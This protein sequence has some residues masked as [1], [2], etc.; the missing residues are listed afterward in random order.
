MTFK[1]RISRLVKE[2]EIRIV[3]Y[4]KALIPLNGKSIIS[5]I[6]NCYPRSLEF[7]I[8]V[9]YR[10]DLIKKYLKITHPDKKFKFVKVDNY[11][12]I[13]S[14]PGYSLLKCKKYLQVPF[15]SHACD[16]VIENKISELT[17]NWVG[18]DKIINKHLSKFVSVKIK[19]NGKANFK[20]INNKGNIF[21]GVAG[22]YDY[23]NFWKSLEKNNF[24]SKKLSKK[25]SYEKQMI[26]GFEEL[27]KIKLKKL[28]WH[29][30]GDDFTYEQIYFKNV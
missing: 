16:A 17:H 30:A 20:R 22:I 3:K 28:K 10:S 14:G 24:F 7:V 2:Q 25:N 29:D 26:D 11:E 23:K 4:H 6:I 21:V 5:N 12:G 8:A 19:G 1:A 18:Y 27:K 15:I 13:G 9:G